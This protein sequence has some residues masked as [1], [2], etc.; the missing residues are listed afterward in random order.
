MKFLDKDMKASGFSLVEL[1]IVVAIIGVLAALAIPKFASFQAKARMTEAKTNLAH[2]YT[3]EEAFYGDNERYETMAAMG[4]D[5]T[6]ANGCTSPNNNLGF[7]VTPCPAA[8][9]KVRYQYEIAAAAATTFL[10]T[11]VSGGAG[12]NKVAPNCQADTWSIDQNKDLQHTQDALASC[13]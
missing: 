7:K 3:L 1:M 13:P 12:N 9:A 5:L 10:A 8:N 6:A 2:L 11:A 4:S